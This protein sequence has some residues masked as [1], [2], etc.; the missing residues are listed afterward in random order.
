M[1]RDVGSG[2]RDGGEER[3]LEILRESA[4][5]S[6]TSDELITK[7]AN[8]AEHYHLAPTRSHLLRPLRL[9]ADATVLEVGAGCGAVTR[10]LGETCATVDAIEPVPRRAVAAR[11]R[12]R[13]LPNVEVFVGEI[14]D[15]PDIPAYDLIVVVGVLEYVGNGS[16][17]LTP[18]REFLD[19][20]S[21]RLKPTGSLVLA[22]ENKLGVKYFS[23][24]AEDHTNRYFD[25]IEGY[26]EAG[27]ART[28]SRLELTALL[29][30]SGLTAETVLA[31]PDYKMPRALLSPE[32]LT[33]EATS[34]LH[35]VPNFPSPDWVV[36]RE[37]VAD[38]R[39]V[40][41]SFVEAGLAADTGNSF[42]ALAG[43][44]GLTDLWD[45]AVGGVFY[46]ND[47][48]ARYAVETR[49]VNEA[50]QVRLDRTRLIETPWSDDLSVLTGSAPFEP[51]Q[52]LVEVFVDTDDPDSVAALLQWKQ[53]V[54][55][56]DTTAGIPLDLVPHNLVVRP[57]RSLVAIDD[58]WR[59]QG[60]EIDD[61]LRRGALT[62]GVGLALRGRSRAPWAG[63]VNYREV[64]R[65]IGAVVGLTAPDWVE[66]AVEAEAALQARIS[67]QPA[68]L[69]TSDDRET[70]SATAFDNILEIRLD[71]QL[72][73][74]PR[75]AELRSRAGTAESTGETADSLRH[76]LHLA[77]V[78]AHDL[79]VAA[80]DQRI[81]LQEH[82]NVLRLDLHRMNEEVALHRAASD[83]Y[84]Q[85]VEGLLAERAQQVAVSTV[86]RSEVEHFRNDVRELSRRA[87]EATGELERTRATLSWRVTAPLRWVRG[88]GK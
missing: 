48:R 8:W 38:E 14:S 82:I 39:L 34:L 69:T 76:Q 1:L 6:S 9:P 58:E 71:S 66:R 85:R 52:D 65:R 28:F 37:T 7:A 51:G 87:T 18:Y 62:L 19:G 33:G 77:R 35:R 80:D 17:D 88:F 64:T 23:G 42:V 27:P 20:L 13:D 5:V 68:Y 16:A 54:E 24:S 2:Y 40:W 75:Q 74:G 4:D 29:G 79:R 15:I 60:G 36:P 25:G 72:R 12:T 22:I 63:C 56:A 67:L 61:V 59:L 43:K 73:F 46:S 26:P 50:G 47:R 55:D 83:A 3:V 53:M 30:E 44:A 45:P 49:I 41:R 10:Y 31:F 11:E 78:D 86:L 84:E 81:Q 57:D 32:R 21:S 70:A